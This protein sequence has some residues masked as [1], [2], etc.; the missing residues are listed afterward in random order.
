M[1]P[2]KVDKSVSYIRRMVIDSGNPRYAASKHSSFFGGITTGQHVRNRFK[3]PV[4]VQKPIAQSKLDED[5]FGNEGKAYNTLNIGTPNGRNGLAF[6]DDTGV[7]RQDEMYY[8]DREDQFFSKLKKGG[9]MDAA[10]YDNLE[11]TTVATSAVYPYFDD[12]GSSIPTA[13]YSQKIHD[14]SKR[15]KKEQEMRE[16]LESKIKKLRREVGDKFSL[17]K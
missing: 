1:N 12:A 16:H 10:L 13:F 5:L 8:D 3:I 17:D 11:A 6:E 7:L 2:N 9:S 15:L 14:Y 4:D